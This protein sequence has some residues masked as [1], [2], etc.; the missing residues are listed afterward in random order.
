[1]HDDDVYVEVREGWFG[2][3][4]GTTA[5][6]CNRHS[7]N[8]REQGERQTATEC[9]GTTP[10]AR[11]CRFPAHCLRATLQQGARGTVLLT[12]GPLSKDLV[13]VAPAPLVCPWARPLVLAPL[14]GICK[15]PCE[16]RASAMGET[17]PGVGAGTRLRLRARCSGSNTGR[18]SPWGPAT[19][20]GRPGVE[21]PTAR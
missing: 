4:L 13:G 11:A 20:K 9:A 18:R 17:V 8:R 6:L 10:W 14:P 15:D 12:P 5:Q 21:S 3:T 16:R 2:W 19:R 7:R 1:M